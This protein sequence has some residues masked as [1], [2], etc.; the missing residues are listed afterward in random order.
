M[1]HG[2]TIDE[3][4]K[5]GLRSASHDPKEEMDVVRGRVL[6]HVLSRAGTAE[7]A[8]ELAQTDGPVFHFSWSRVAMASVAAGLLLAILI[9]ISPPQARQFAVVENP[10][11]STTSLQA[12]EIV[13]AISTG[14]TVVLADGSRVEMRSGA[15]LR[16]E[17]AEDGVRVGLNKGSVI[18]NAAHQR[19]GHLYLLTTDVTVSV[20]GTVFLVSVEEEGSRVAVIQGE[21]GLKRGEIVKTLLPGEQVATA[22]T[23]ARIPVSEEIAWSRRAQEHAALLRQLQEA[24]APQPPTAV[25]NPPAFEVASVRPSAAGNRNSLMDNRNGRVRMENVTIQQIVEYAYS[26][27]SYQVSGPDL[28]KADRYTIEAKAPSGTPDNLLPA[29]AQQLLDERFRMALRWETKEIPVYALII[30]KDGPRLK[31]SEEAGFGF[32]TGN[33]SGDEN[34]YVPVK[35]RGNLSLFVSGLS[36]IV[37]DRPVVDRTGLTGRYFEEF[38]YVPDVAVRQGAVGP[39]LFD[40]IAK[41]GL[42]LEPVRASLDFLVIEHIEKPSEN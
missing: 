15:E 12:E 27:R 2:K 31:E 25:P 41:L 20:I 29:M 39:S 5:R 11:G 42:R 36:G 10:D 17:R 35:F 1:R 4:L 14:T 7:A 26:V 18:V 16:L 22:L 34:G 30:G 38:S 13:R 9:V 23:M 37:G 40:A 3:V 28:L 32:V 24:A 6:Q 21:V 33:R 19:Q 8:S